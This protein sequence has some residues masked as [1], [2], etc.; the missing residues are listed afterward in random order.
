MQRPTES[1]VEHLVTPADRE[2]R[3]AL[4]YRLQ[5]D[6]L[7][8]QLVELRRYQVRI[9]VT[10]L[11]DVGVAGIH[12]VLARKEELTEAAVLIVVAGMDGAL[13]SVVGGLAVP[14]SV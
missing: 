9:R 7:H 1:D 11:T 10:R 5:R 13:P 3:D 4:V 12:R 8:L 14:V 2:Q 6:A